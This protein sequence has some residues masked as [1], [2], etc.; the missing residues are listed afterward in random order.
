[1]IQHEIIMTCPIAVNTNVGLNGHWTADDQQNC[2]NKQQESTMLGRVNRS[3]HKH[4]TVI[5]LI[6]MSTVKL[7]KSTASR[8]PS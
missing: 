3:Q 5:F 2:L 8:N 6:N 4:Q 1:M 7:R